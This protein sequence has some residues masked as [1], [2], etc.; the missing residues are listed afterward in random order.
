MLDSLMHTFTCNVLVFVPLSDVIDG[1]SDSKKQYWDRLWI[2]RRLDNQDNTHPL[3]FK[4]PH[5][6]K[7]VLNL[8]LISTSS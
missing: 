6:G 3:M 1:L 4:H 5:N 2:S 8:N 7:Q